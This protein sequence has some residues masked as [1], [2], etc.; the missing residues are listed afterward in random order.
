MAYAPTYS[1]VTWLT[2]ELV[3]E[4]KREARVPA[5]S[6]FTDA[7]ILAEADKAI[8]SVMSEPFVTNLGL[9]GRWLDY[10]DVLASSGYRS[11]AEYLVPNDSASGTVSHVHFYETSSDQPY[12]L[13]HI[14]AAQALDI[15]APGD[16]AGKPRYWY[17]RDGRV[18]VSPVPSNADSTA[19]VRIYFPRRHPK[20][21]VT[22]S[23]VGTVSSVDQGTN[24]ITLSATHP[25]NWPTAP[26]A[27]DLYS[28]YSPHSPLLTRLVISSDSGADITYT[29]PTEGETDLSAA[30]SATKVALA[31][32]SDCV[33]LPISMRKALTAR[34]AS[35]ILRQ[36]GDEARANSLWGVSRE[37]LGSTQNQM[38]PRAKATKPRMV[39]RHSVLRVGS[40]RWRFW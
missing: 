36:I 19:R 3:D 4:V 13:E 7:L 38:Q 1:G 14:T 16:N 11:G 6:D 10:A 32:T 37:E 28:A 22:T 35:Y 21:V 9:A 25:T 27:V 12:E 30:G 5:S 18:V 34:T 20:L 23:N 26:Y 17:F 39:N 29:P 31:G 2:S 24:V 8:W 15:R 40:R 33:Q